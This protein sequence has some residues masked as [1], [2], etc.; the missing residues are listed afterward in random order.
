VP[1]SLRQ[2]DEGKSSRSNRHRRAQSHAKENFSTLYC[3]DI[4]GTAPKGK[5]AAIAKSYSSLRND[6]IAGTKPKMH[7]CKSQRSSFSLRTDDIA[8]ASAQKYYEKFERNQPRNPLEP[9]ELSS[10]LGNKGELKHFG[11]KAKDRFIR[12]H[13]AVKDI[14][15]AMARDKF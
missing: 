2:Y 7:Y 13:I 8:G 9:F 10:P 1:V 4:P 3:A 14:E 5:P 12:D 15:G 11:P 6:D